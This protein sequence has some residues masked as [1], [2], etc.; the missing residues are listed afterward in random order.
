MFELIEKLAI[1]IFYILLIFSNLVAILGILNLFFIKKP[2]INNSKVS[3]NYLV[4]ILIPARNEA[5]NIKRCVYSLLDQ[6]YKNFEIIVLDDDSV[7]DTFKIVSSISK[8]DERVRVVQGK[9][10]ENGWLGKNWACHQLSRLAKGDFYLFIDADTKLQ[11][12]VLEETIIEMETSDIDLISLF[13]KRVTTTFVDKIISVSMGWFIFCCLPLIFSNR[14]PIF[15]SAFGQ[16]LLFRK[17]S[18]L[19]IGGH[20]SIKNKILDDFELARSITTSNLVL[21]LFDGTE[22][23]TTFSYSNEKEALDGLSKSI[24]PFFN[25]KILPFFILWIIFMSMGLIPFILFFGGFFDIKLSRYKELMTYLIW[26]SLTFSWS[27]ASYRSKQG[28]FYGIMFPF[29]TTLTAI[30]G[31]FSILTFTYK[32]VNWKE[33]NISPGIDKSTKAEEVD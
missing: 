3:N 33:R 20:E 17:S 12:K 29:I 26:G 5:Y 1:L 19:L 7:D 15:S 16:Y 27:M 8:L 6:T 25:N 22:R 13:P 4:S 28:I 18:Y 30:I 21:K 10:I 24:F 9:A 14:N 32:N 31:V 23:L 2:N 11:N